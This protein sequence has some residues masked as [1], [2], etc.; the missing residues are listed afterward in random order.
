MYTPAPTYIYLILAFHTSLSAKLFYQ[1]SITICPIK[2][3]DNLVISHCILFKMNT[4]DN[5]Q[6][7]L[8]SSMTK[9][10][11]VFLCMRFNYIAIMNRNTH[12]W[13]AGVVTNYQT[14]STCNLANDWNSRLQK[15]PHKWE[16]VLL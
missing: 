14:F 11:D 1:N 2:Y 7:Q 4:Y 13:K 16:I 5:L 9:L 10:H 12:T 8:F 6:L 15:S 3:S